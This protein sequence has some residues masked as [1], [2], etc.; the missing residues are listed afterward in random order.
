[1]PT[2]I[3]DLTVTVSG[4]TVTLN[5]VNPTDTARNLVFRD[6]KMIDDTETGITSYVDSNVPTGTHS[7]QVVPI[8]DTATISATVGTTP[9]PPPP[10]PPASMLLG[11]YAGQETNGV[12]NGVPILNK[13]FAT[14]TGAPIGIARYYLDGSDTWAS[15]TAYLAESFA[16]TTGM[17]MN[18]CIPT[19][20]K[21]ITGSASQFW[22]NGAAGQF[23]SA[24]QTM[25]EY[26]VS[27]GF[28]NAILSPWW[29]WDGTQNPSVP[30]T[31][32]DYTNA[33]ETYNQFA[34]VA[35]AVSADFHLSWYC[36]GYNYSYESWWANCV[37]EAQYIDSVSLDFYDQNWGGWGSV[38]TPS[39]AGLT[40]AQHQYA[41]TNYQ[42]KI[43]T[44]L[45][46][47]AEKIGK[48]MGFGEFGIW[49]PT[50][51]NYGGDDPYWMNDFAAW[52]KA[53]NVYWACYFNAGPNVID[54]SS[55]AP[56]SAAAFA[57]NFG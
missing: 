5:W 16:G 33:A 13:A 39:G 48:P 53:N 49:Q 21:Q 17:R 43:L 25:L 1:M 54:P 56:L 10:P 7:Y 32:T 26:F 46:A 23:N 2:L 4:S 55:K 51:T 6:S 41:W 22:I 8:G 37:P 45:A 19:P 28:G 27:L 34:S 36:G 24:W 29:E 38:G 14:A 15:S 35:R 31:A 9:P 20:N 50:S 30:A 18:L 57:A 44:W 11:V 42:L 12:S 52:L 47:E 40:Q 3:T